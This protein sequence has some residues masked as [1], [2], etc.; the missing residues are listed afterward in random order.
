METALYIIAVIILLAGA[1]GYAWMWKPARDL[2]AAQ[3][4]AKNAPAV[5]AAAPDAADAP[6]PVPPAQITA[7]L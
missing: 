3:L 5:S 6:A 4:E 7:Q 2:A 1:F